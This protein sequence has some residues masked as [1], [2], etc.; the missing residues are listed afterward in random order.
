M[1]EKLLACRKKALSLLKYRDRTE[2]ELVTRLEDQE[3]TEEEIEDAVAYVRS[4]HYIDDLRYAK[5]FAEMHS[6]SRSVKRIR[7]DLQKK[8]IS[9]EYIE[10]ALEEIAFDDSAALRKELKK[11]MKGRQ[12]L[13]DEEKQKIAAG[14]Y[15]KGFRTSD[16]FREMDAL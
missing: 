11:R 1:E 4:F 3:F 9:A 12:E 16:I 14:L 2:W 7:Q 10:L 15:R 6:E 13:A 8:H 5:R